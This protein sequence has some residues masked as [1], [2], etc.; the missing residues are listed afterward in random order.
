MVKLTKTQAGVGDISEIIDLAERMWLPAFS[1]YFS[2]TEL[3][4]LF[5]GMYNSEK[6]LAAIQ[7]PSYEFYIVENLQHMRVGYFATYKTIEYLKLDKIYVAP[8]LKGRGI[9]KWMY[10]E[11]IEQARQNNFRKILLNVNRRNRPAINF[12]KKLGFKVVKE[13]DIPGPNGFIYDD[14]VMEVEI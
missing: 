2:E 9:G 1:P 6:I 13:E 14:F 10:N 8:E 11:I 3:Y 4:S 7:N 5:N 12:Y